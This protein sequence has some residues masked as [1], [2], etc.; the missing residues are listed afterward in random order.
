MGRPHSTRT[1]PDARHAVE[2]THIG[3]VADGENFYG[4]GGYLGR[5][6]GMSGNK[7]FCF[8]RAD[9][10]YTDLPDLPGDRPGGGLVIH[11]NPDETRT[12]VYAGSVDRTL[13][14][15]D[16]HIDYDTTWTL[17]LDENGAQWV[18][19][20]DM[21]DLL[22]LSTVLLEFLPNQVGLYRKELIKFGW[23]HLKREESIAKH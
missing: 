4:V 11:T 18:Q 3:Q 10:E 1:R 8:N 20:E 12:L 6:P 16:E 19:R 9:N 14:S 22:Q 23:A 21:P 13:N 17:N 2:R 7:S 5:H 15:Y